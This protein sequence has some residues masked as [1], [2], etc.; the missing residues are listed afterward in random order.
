MQKLSL[1]INMNVNE[2]S[3]TCCF[4]KKKTKPDTDLNNNTINNDESWGSNL[5]K[6]AKGY[7]AVVS[8][9][10]LKA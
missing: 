5:S 6:S 2:S 1:S 4:A 10:E 9:S 7:S 8:Q 3:I